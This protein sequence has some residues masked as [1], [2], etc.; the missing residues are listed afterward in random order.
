VYIDSTLPDAPFGVLAFGEIGKP[1]IHLGGSGLARRA[2]PMPSSGATRTEL[3]TDMTFGSDGTVS[4]TT[5]TTASGAFGIWL[6]NAAR[7][8]GDN[9]ES[10][11]ITLLR[12]HGTP[13]TG[14]FSFDP[15][16]TGGDSYTVHGK[17]QINNQSELLRGGFFAPW[18][19]LRILP[20]PGDVLGGPMFARDLSRSEPTFCYPGIESEELNLTLPEGRVLGGLPP[21]LKIDSEV[22]RYRSHWSLN[23]QLV[24]VSRE[25]QSLAPGPVCEGQVREDMADVLSKV[26]ADLL[27]PVGITQDKLPGQPAAA[28]GSATNQ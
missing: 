28:P 3:K 13:G 22:V 17:F 18:T 14:T 27:S 6:R 24:T 10:A 11:A 8:F 19:G 20:R 7:S 2:I 25:F 26:R 21:D 23:G 9:S 4:G 15:P 1:A 12:Q 16:D 5:T